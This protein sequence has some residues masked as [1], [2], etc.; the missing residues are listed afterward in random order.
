MRLPVARAFLEP[1]VRLNQQDKENVDIT[2]RANP[3]E[4]PHGSDQN[5]V[6]GII[7]AV[8][9]AALQAGD[10]TP[11]LFLTIVGLILGDLQV[12]KKLSETRPDALP[13]NFSD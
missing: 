2:R 8:Q 13:P 7:T 1:P 9:I 6:K 5:S 10:D 3:G 4:L 12:F 11:M